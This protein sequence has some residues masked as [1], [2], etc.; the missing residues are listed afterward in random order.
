MFTFKIKLLAA[1][2][3]YGLS[4][5]V[6]TQIAE[7]KLNQQHI[8]EKSLKKASEIFITKDKMF[9]RYI[10]DSNLKLLSIKN[11]KIFQ[12]YQ[13]NQSSNGSE[14]ESFFLDIATTSDNIMQL[15]YLDKS[16]MERV[17]INRKSYAG[18]AYIVPKEKLQDKSQRYY[19]AEV[20]SRKN[21]EFWYSNLDLNIEHTEIQKPVKPV[22]RL[23]I[24]TTLNGEKTG[25]L[26]LNIFMKN[27]L[28]ELG[29]DSFNNIYL[30]DKD[31][32]MIVDSLHKH[33]WSRYLEK[34]ATLASHFPDEAVDKITIEDNYFGKNIYASKIFLKNGE[35]IR[36][37]IA[38]KTEH[39]DA[40]LSFFIS[41]II[42]ILLGVFLISLP[43]SYFFSKIPIKLKE[44]VD[45]QKMEQDI[46]L[47]LF[48]L[49]DAVLFKWNN[50]EHWSISSVSKSVEKLLG[51]RESDFIDA[52]ITYADC[53]H[54]DDL[55]EVMSE[56]EA[57][58]KSKAYFFEHKPYRVITK[59][60]EL[61]WILDS[62]VIVRNK[63]DEIVN[64][65]GYLTDI[66]ELK[67]QELALKKLSRT[68]QLTQIYNRMHIDEILQTQYYRFNRSHE[69]CSIILVDIDYFKLVNDEYGHIVGDKILIEFADL[70]K[71]SIRAG[72]VIGRWGGEEF[73]IILPHTNL[74]QALI[75][76]EKLR[77][78]IDNNIFTQLRHK[79]A[80]FGVSTFEEGMSIELLIDE[81]DKALYESKERGRNR[82]TTQQEEILE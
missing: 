37:V 59:N 25:L 15:R 16:G 53:I 52:H 22:I 42:F 12:A 57:A 28:R 13:E 61:K 50:D 55:A 56:V 17:R 18:D 20:M 40:E 30:F 10:K 26:I 44:K 60:K 79:T 36:M 1:F 64:F 31:G 69:V 39:L 48:D 27:F 38:P 5:V 74:S 75:L 33:C 32:K 45:K 78:L 4:L 24:A 51:Y 66:T 63:D 6:A 19:F 9:Q 76:A 11:S 62:T 58:I 14:I 54:S 80:S 49:G 77:R 3:I 23:A 21:S 47:S 46:L 82:V 67:K 73:L 7:F 70:M 41:N 43:L 65:I 34:N 71:N 8:K 72:D 29:E 68:D 35:Q 2:I 81:A